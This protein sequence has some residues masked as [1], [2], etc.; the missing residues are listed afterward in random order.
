MSRATQQNE[1]GDLQ[2]WDKCQRIQYSNPRPKQRNVKARHFRRQAYPRSLW[3][4]KYPCRL[5]KTVETC[6]MVKRDEPNHHTISHT[7]PFLD[8]FC[9]QGRLL[10]LSDPPVI[11]RCRLRGRSRR[12]C[13]G[14]RHARS[15]PPRG[16]STPLFRRAFLRM[17]QYING[18]GQ[19]RLRL[20]QGGHILDGKQIE[21][22]FIGRTDDAL[23]G[24]SL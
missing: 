21:K 18:A 11:A 19:M 20:L 4:W 10:R 2:A 5:R 22:F 23:Q 8:R 14:R 24:G 15:M 13:N 6:R 17:A 1:L 12:H 16:C 9:R 3:E 7:P